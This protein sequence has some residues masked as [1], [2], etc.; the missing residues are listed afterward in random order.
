[1]PVE[2]SVVSPKAASNL[3]ACIEATMQDAG[4]EKESMQFFG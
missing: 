4:S 1:M 2:C 3:Q